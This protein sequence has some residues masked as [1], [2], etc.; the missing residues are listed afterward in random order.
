MLSLV[1]TIFTNW[2]GLSH[3]IQL[4]KTARVS[5]NLTS[6]FLLFFPCLRW[7]SWKSIR[8]DLSLLLRAIRSLFF[9]RILQKTKL[10]SGF[11]NQSKKST[12]HEHG[13]LCQS[14][15]YDRQQWASLQN[16]AHTWQPCTRVWCVVWRGFST[17]PLRGTT[18]LYPITRAAGRNLIKRPR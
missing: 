15:V 17:F 6:S 9:C 5:T 4:A 1:L 10:Y 18:R 12:T 13:F 14:S 11:K 7:N 2:R 16:H 3:L 8:L